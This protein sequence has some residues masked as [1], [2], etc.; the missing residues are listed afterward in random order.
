M[1]HTFMWKARRRQSWC[2][3]WRGETDEDAL[4]MMKLKQRSKKLQ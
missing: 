2:S 1:R 3:R 4:W